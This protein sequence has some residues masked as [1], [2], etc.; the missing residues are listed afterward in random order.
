MSRDNLPNIGSKVNPVIF[1][2]RGLQAYRED[3]FWY[4]RNPDITKGF[5]SGWIRITDPQTEQTFDSLARTAP[6]AREPIKLT[7]S[8]LAAT[9]EAFKSHPNWQDVYLFHDG[10]VVEGQEF[11]ATM[12]SRHAQLVSIQQDGIPMNVSR[13]HHYVQKRLAFGE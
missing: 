9:V 1:R 10:K 8:Q 13:K 2:T 3:G 12:S 6:P 5:F 11:R 7:E 4:A